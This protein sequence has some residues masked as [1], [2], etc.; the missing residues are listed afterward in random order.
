MRFANTFACALFR[1]FAMAESYLDAS[2]DNGLIGIDD[3]SL[4]RQDRNFNDG[5]LVLYVHNSLKATVITR[6]RAEKH[7][8]PKIP[9]YLICS[10]QQGQ[11][12]RR[13]FLLRSST[14]PHMCHLL[15]APIG[16][17]N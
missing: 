5:G 15:M 17:N 9:E 14:D 13:L 11:P 10:V 4:I 3:F 7:D 12:A 2:V 6:S 16:L 8:K 1:L